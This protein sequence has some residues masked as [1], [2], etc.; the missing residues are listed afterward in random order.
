VATGAEGIER[1][2]T[3]HFDML[4]LDLGLTDMDGL[5]VCREVREWSQIPIIVI[6]VRENERDKV[7]ALDLGADDYI[8][9]PFGIGELLAR[10]RA[11]LRRVATH[12]D[13]PVHSIGALTVDLARRRVLR[14]E[15][16]I[17]LTPTEYEL[18]RVL[19]L[20]A[21]RVVTHRQLL[22]E[23][24]LTS[25]YGG[26]ASEALRRPR[27][28][29]LHRDRAGSGVSTPGVMVPARRR[30]LN[31]FLMRSRLLLMPS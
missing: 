17:R 14:G 22:R 5:E 1:I 11:N 31:A 30:N 26:A 10:I 3:D 13:Q 16:E 18:L 29:R 15:H 19:A 7:A 2:A 4:L 28:A 24:T 21:G 8:T 12:G 6:S 9:K 20:Y 27:Y 23:A 25:A